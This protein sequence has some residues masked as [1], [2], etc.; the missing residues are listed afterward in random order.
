MLITVFNSLCFLFIVSFVLSVV[1]RVVDYY[2]KKDE[3]PPY[4]QKGDEIVWG[5][6][7]RENKAE[8]E[9]YR[10]NSAPP[11][12]SALPVY[13]APRKPTK[14]WETAYTQ[15]WKSVS[16]AVRVAAGWRCQGCGVNL[17]GNRNLLHAHHKNR[18]KNDNSKSNLIALCVFCHCKQP[19]HYRL[20]ESAK[21]NGSYQK[22][23]R[24]RRSQGI[25]G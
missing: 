10:R 18:M 9:P 22:T 19:Y 17:N 1:L 5:F 11:A 4:P 25:T 23:V 12:P 24:L 8:K 13:P 16:R 21:K 20:R 15:D 6:W 14:P 7:D 3:K 2:T